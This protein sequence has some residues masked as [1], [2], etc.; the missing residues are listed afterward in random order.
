MPS[1][2]SKPGLK[3]VG[4]V[5]LCCF[6]NLFYFGYD[7]I[8]KGTFEVDGESITR[9][10]VASIIFRGKEDNGEKYGRFYALARLDTAPQWQW[11]SLRSHGSNGAK[12]ALVLGVMTNLNDFDYDFLIRNRNVD[13]IRRFQK[14][15]KGLDAENVLSINSPP[16]QSSHVIINFKD[17]SFV[18]IAQLFPLSSTLSFCYGLNLTKEIGDYPKNNNHCP[19]CLCSAV[20][21]TRSMVT[22]ESNQIF[23]KLKYFEMANELNKLSRFVPCLPMTSGQLNISKPSDIYIVGDTPSL[24]AEPSRAVRQLFRDH[25]MPLVLEGGT[26][27]GWYRNCCTIWDDVDVDFSVPN[28]FV[29]NQFYQSVLNVSIFFLFS[30]HV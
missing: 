28:S 5:L 23:S 24:K 15:N 27:L 19:P 30:F 1:L 16:L 17:G 10:S 6:F 8:I 3:W 22:L 7:H 14:P 2:F 9:I 26:L 11:A 12:M 25:N 13:K 18:M 29:N 21:S 20:F 4:V